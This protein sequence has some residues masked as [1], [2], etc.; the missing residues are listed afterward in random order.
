MILRYLI[1]FLFLFFSKFTS[2]QKLYYLVIKTSPDYYG[3]YNVRHADSL[4]VIKELNNYFIGLHKKLYLA[5]ELDT[6]YN[7]GDSTVALISL[8]KQYKWA[9]FHRGNK[10]SEAI[11]EAALGNK[12]FLEKKMHPGK[13]ADYETKILSY[14]ENHGYPFASILLD[15]VSFSGDQIQGRLNLFKGPEIVFDSIQIL[16]NTK[17]KSR[18]IKRHLRIFPGQPYSQAKIN[19][20]EA[21]IRELGFLR[22]SRDPIVEFKNGKA[23]L[24]LFLEEK[25]NNQIDGLIGFLPNQAQN[26]K[27][28]VTGEINL[29]LKNLLGTGKNLAFEWRKYDA[30][31]HIMNLLYFHPKILGSNLDLKFNLNM[32]KQ[33]S[34]FLNVFRGLV[35]TQPLKDKGKIHFSTGLKT[36]RRLTTTNFSDSRR[37][38]LSDYDNYTYGLAYTYSALDDIYYPKKGWYFELGGNLGN[39]QVRRDYN[40]PDS[41]YR[42]ISLN[43]I[44]YSLSFFASKF[45]RLGKN[46]VV[47]LKAEGGQLINQQNNI[48]LN[49]LY[50]IGGLKSLRGFNENYFFATAY[51]VGTLEYRIFTDE[52]SYLFL[53][54]DQGYVENNIAE[55][56]KTDYPLGVGA[57]LSF[58]TPAGVFSFVYSLGRSNDQKMSL[59][60]SKIHFG[61]VSRF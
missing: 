14:S 54:C 38:L 4:S 9:K 3:K 56:T 50:R 61:I 6:I 32:L 47:M 40:L 53:F 29:N 51:G 11:E 52:T 28:L 36:S 7:S 16:G 45:H 27:L 5:A 58:A 2:A 13:L 46:G 12:F 25:K 49:D 57:G 20:I 41:L 48:F 19:E 39:K 55:S 24:H 59:N 15:S 21:R 60:L 34:S 44:Q 1:L 22:Q 33:D 23:Y 37:L 31:S 30:Q 18:Y 8:G 42:N 17:V 26:N 35:L 43:S 10:E